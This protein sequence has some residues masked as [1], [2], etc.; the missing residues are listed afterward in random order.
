[1]MR[2]MQVHGSCAALD[3]M[4]VLFTGAPG[5]GKSDLVLR[6]R[7]HGFVLVADDR[8]DIRGLQ[9]SAPTPL[10]G[11]L[12][13]HGLGIFRLPYLPRADLA[14]VVELGHEVPRLPQPE[15]HP[16]LGLPLIRLD[17]TH[18]SAPERVC[19]ALECVL[20]RVAT[21]VGAFAP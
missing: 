9:A 21:L 6:L 16:E 1:M 20:G 12:E 7:T 5:S 11:L 2:P 3:G 13:V 8:V 4:G 18:A 15:R 14:L 10:A 19:L 17:P